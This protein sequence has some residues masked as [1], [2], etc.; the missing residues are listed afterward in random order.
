MS[1]SSISPNSLHF[2]FPLGFNSL[3][4]VPCSTH[5]LPSFCTWLP[6]SCSHSEHH[7][8]A[9][10]GGEE[11]YCFDSLVLGSRLYQSIQETLAGTPSINLKFYYEAPW[12]QVVNTG[13][14]T[15]GPQP[16]QGQVDDTPTA[17][18]QPTDQSQGKA[19]LSPVPHSY[20]QHNTAERASHSGSEHRD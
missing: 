5:F 12:W 14:G 11:A 20:L 2:S 13:T 18:E 17:D 8:G 19:N 7:H 1:S 10:W 9:G 16:S 4:M 3:F 6:I 15:G